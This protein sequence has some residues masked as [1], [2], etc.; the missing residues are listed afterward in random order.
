[1][2]AIRKIGLIILF[3]LVTSS[4][5]F[6]GKLT[7]EQKNE[8]IKRAE[9]SVI[10]GWFRA[11]GFGAMVVDNEETGK[12]TVVVSLIFD[13]RT[14]E[15]VPNETEILHQVKYTS[16]CLWEY[17]LCENLDALYFAVQSWH[18]GSINNDYSKAFI[19]YNPK[20]IKMTNGQPEREWFQEYIVIKE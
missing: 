18:D 4:Q 14:W 20:D 11:P 2:K 19:V 13:S 12:A 8:C 10:N 3:I 17:G 15:H 16:T 1:M 6:A 7:E 5:C 9:D